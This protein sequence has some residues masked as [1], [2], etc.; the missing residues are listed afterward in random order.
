ME[1]SETT[2]N[3]H[4]LLAC[5]L[6]G[7]NLPPVETV[8][9]WDEHTFEVVQAWAN[10][11]AREHKDGHNADVT[12]N[13]PE[14]LAAIHDRVVYE[15]LHATHKVDG[16]LTFYKVQAWGH[17]D[18]RAAYRWAINQGQANGEARDIQEPD[19]LTQYVER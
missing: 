7:D 18:R 3:L 2:Q 4:K 15:A 13:M 19:F 9:D 1:A 11:L 5:F 17:D 12:H 14:V 10:E 16:H 8:Q 6:D